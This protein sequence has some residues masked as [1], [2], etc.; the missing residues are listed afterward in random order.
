MSSFRHFVMSFVPFDN[1]FINGKSFLNKIIWFERV[2][3]CNARSS[4]RV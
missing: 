4:D 3:L 2:I 1:G